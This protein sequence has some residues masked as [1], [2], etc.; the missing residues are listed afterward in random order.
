MSPTVIALL[1]IA[2][3]IWLALIVWLVKSDWTPTRRPSRAIRQSD[4]RASD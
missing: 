3:P 1:L 2:V 4:W